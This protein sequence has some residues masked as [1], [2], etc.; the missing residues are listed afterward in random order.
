[1]ALIIVLDLF[2][3]LGVVSLGNNREV[4]TSRSMFIIFGVS[5]IFLLT[6]VTKVDIFTGR[7]YEL[8]HRYYG[9]IDKIIMYIK[10]NYHNPEKLSIG[11]NI[12]QTTYIYY[13]G[14]SVICDENTDCLKNPPDILL[15]RRYGLVERD[16]TRFDQYL[17]N[18]KYDPVYIPILDYPSNNIP[19]FSLSLRHLFKTP[20]TNN[21]N[22]M[23]IM[24][25]KKVP[26]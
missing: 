10:E 5:V 3:L 6:C 1:L 22:E 18:A 2:L 11:T 26:K 16:I 7:I 24:Y 23:V 4:I 19:E 17:K 14:S 15:P 13:L 12:E 25:I 9:P 8:T 21:K 20:E